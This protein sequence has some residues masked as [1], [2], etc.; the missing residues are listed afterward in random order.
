MCDT[1]GIIK[2]DRALFGKN[3]DRSANEPQVIEFI[4]GHKTNKNKVKLTYIEIDEV[5]EVYSILISRPTWMW[6]AEMGVNEF[7]VCIGNEAIFT[8]KTN[9]KNSLIGMDLVRLGLERSKTAIE[10][11]NVITALVSKYGQGGN[12][13]YDHNFFYN[14]SFLIMDSKELYVVE[15]EMNT[16]RII[17]KDKMAISN[18]L[19]IVNADIKIKENKLVTYFSKAKERQGQTY[20]K[21][22]EMNNVRDVVKTLRTHKILKNNVFCKGTV[23]SPCMH[24][25]GIIGDHTTSSLVVELVDGN[26]N[27]WFTGTSSPCISVFKYYK[28][29]E[30][31][32]YPIS[33]NKYWN[34]RENIFRDL[35]GYKIL[36][37]Y[38][39]LRDKIEDEFYNNKETVTLKEMLE[40]ENDLFNKLKIMKIK[41][42]NVSIRYKNYWDNKN[43]RLKEVEEKNDN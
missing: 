28:F 43:K 16:Y 18:C 38:Y 3:S 5:E 33:N 9:K 19:S 41:K 23:S 22:D 14:N 32:D 10:A 39:E 4:E 29:G 25:G 2:K 40:K 24:A 7:G 12:H 17:K 35:I 8:K 37:E 6:G 20:L 34:E 1:I 27:V 31:I 15:T 26:I 36:N 21:I 30:K 13:G 42:Q 11:V